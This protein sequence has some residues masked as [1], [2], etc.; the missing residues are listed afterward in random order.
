M[1]SIA[2]RLKGCGR[3]VSERPYVPKYYLDKYKTQYT[4]E[5]AVDFCL[6]PLTFARNWFVTPKTLEDY[7]NVVF[8]NDNTELD[9]ND[10]IV[11]HS[12]MT[13]QKTLHSLMVLEA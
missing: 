8:L 4:C 12:L 3:N 1:S 13:I 5:K 6:S 11:L 9:N 10:L 2:K 7:D